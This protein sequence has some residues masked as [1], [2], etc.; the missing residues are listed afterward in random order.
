MNKALLI[1]NAGSSSIKFAL[2]DNTSLEII[3]HGEIESICENASIVILN[4]GQQQVMKQSISPSGYERALRVL[5][6]WIKQLHERIELIAAGHRVV[7][8]GSFYSG[9]IIVNDDAL[10]KLTS[11]IPLAPLHQPHNLEA[12]KIIRRLYP[13]L[14]QIACFDTAFHHRQNYL[15]KRFAI[16]ENLTDEGIIRYGFHGISYE[17]IASVLPDYI[18]NKAE[19]KVIV[20]HLGHGS[21]LCAMRDRQSQ[22]TSMGLTALDGLVMGT[23]CG[24]IDPGVILYLIQEKKWSVEK[25]NHLLYLESG[26]LGVSGFSSDMRA[27]QSSSNP[28]AIEAVDLYC[29]TAAKEL[30]A[31]C[32]IL[33]GCDVIVFTAGI[34]EHSAIVRQKIL[35]RLKWL[36]VVL[37]KEANNRHASII[38]KKSSKILVCVIPTN[39]QYV[40]AQHTQNAIASIE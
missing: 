25:V 17:F 40:I 11:L 14:P 35:E 10:N 30:S 38:S 5:F 16:P 13:K 4:E 18:Q 3:Y 2:Y 15:A 33:E 34:G 7:H 23:R 21:S 20:A 8:G 19:G 9:P 27:L 29:Y 12:I 6:D 28:K 1:I 31:L 26:L 37:D 32:V 22:A 36:G 24:T 39:E